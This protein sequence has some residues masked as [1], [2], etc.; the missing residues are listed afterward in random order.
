ML[1][2]FAFAVSSA[3]VR[4][5]ACGSG[6][7]QSETG[8]LGCIHCDSLGDFYQELRGQTFCLHCVKNTQRYLGVLSA[9]NRT[10]CQCKEGVRSSL[11]RLPTGLGL[12]EPTALSAFCAG[13]YNRN[14]E[15]GEVLPVAFLQRNARLARR[16]TVTV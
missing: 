6:Y 5:S 4:S 1:E 8:Q 11:H 7:F 10:A 14:E 2:P 16:S 13:Y 12:R 9:A 15:P 3:S